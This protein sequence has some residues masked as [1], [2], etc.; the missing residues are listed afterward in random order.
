MRALPTYP[1][2]G[3]PMRR[4]VSPE[5]A[6]KFTVS[7]TGSGK[8]LLYSEGKLIKPYDYVASDFSK[9]LTKEPQGKQDMG[10]ENPETTS[11]PLHTSGHDS[12]QY[13]F[14]HI[15]IQVTISRKGALTRQSNMGG[16]QQ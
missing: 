12:S 16:N 9:L 5:E 1:G 10:S 14:A 8:W 4:R 15:G 2:R 11:Q 7:R 6:L 3:L 13:T